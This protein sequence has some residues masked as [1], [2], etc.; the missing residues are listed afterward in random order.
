ME[1]YNEHTPES[2]TLMPESKFWTL[3]SQSMLHTSASGPHQ[4]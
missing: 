4:Y 3:Y 2:Y 1:M